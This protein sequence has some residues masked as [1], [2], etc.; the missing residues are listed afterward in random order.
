MAF[1]CKFVN[2]YIY[3]YIYIYYV[4]VPSLLFIYIML[5][6]IPSKQNATGGVLEKVINKNSDPVEALQPA[7]ILKV[8]P[9]SVSPR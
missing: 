8:D 7:I 4:C 9:N 3:I 2:L 5:R 1:T 6:E